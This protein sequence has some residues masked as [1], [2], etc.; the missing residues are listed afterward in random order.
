MNARNIK[1]DIF[2][3]IYWTIYLLKFLEAGQLGLIR[4]DYN[5]I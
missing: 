2:S 5:R 3:R 4:I 1:N